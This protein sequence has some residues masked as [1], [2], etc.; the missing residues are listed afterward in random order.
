[1]V[2]V[3]RFSAGAARAVPASRRVTAVHFILTVARLS[4]DEVGVR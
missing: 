3:W 2:E 1:V 4:I